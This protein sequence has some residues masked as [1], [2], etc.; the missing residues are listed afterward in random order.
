[1][2]GYIAITPSGRA[3]TLQR[4]RRQICIRR[5]LIVKFN[6]LVDN[7]LCLVY[8]HSLYSECGLSQ[9][10]YPSGSEWSECHLHDLL[11][12]PSCQSSFFSLFEKIGG[13]IF[14]ACWET[15]VADL[16]MRGEL[17]LLVS[18]WLQAPWQQL[19]TVQMLLVDL[20]DWAESCDRWVTA[21][22]EEELEMEHRTVTLGSLHALKFRCCSI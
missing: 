4:V 11:T 7:S 14:P 5:Q 15:A 2:W 18:A 21:T 16:L 20:R 3:V 1:M 6:E 8:F 19:H 12:L 13:Q 10:D 9:K 22:D 17:Y